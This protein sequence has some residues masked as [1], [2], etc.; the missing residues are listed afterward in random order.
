MLKYRFL[1]LGVWNIGLIRENKCLI[2]F[3]SKYVKM[4][5]LLQNQWWLP[6][7]I[8]LLSFSS[9]LKFEM[10]ENIACRNSVLCKDRSSF[11]SARILE[12]TILNFQRTCPAESPPNSQIIH[13]FLYNT[14]RYH[15]GLLFKRFLKVLLHHIFSI[16][17]LVCITVNKHTL[18]KL[19]KAVPLPQCVPFLDLR[20]CHLAT[21]IVIHCTI[22]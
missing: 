7:L 20:S 1:I 19:S 8:L 16:N 13:I 11:F 4:Q 10:C 6:P 22:L 5:T 14:Q 9:C 18:S 2:L 17:Q 3:F 21:A 15:H 12:E